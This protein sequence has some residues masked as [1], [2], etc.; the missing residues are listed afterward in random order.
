M[1]KI[2]DKVIMEFKEYL[3]WGEKSENTIEKYIRDITFFAR[4]LCGKEVTKILVLEYKKELCKKYAS[5]SVNG[6]ISSLNSFFGF[7]EWHDARIKS[8]KIQRQIFSNEKRELTKAEY[9]RLLR[10]AKNKNDKRLYFLMQTVC[11][12]GIRISDDI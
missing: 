6:A 12:T 7:M 2:T 1:R 3:I 9:E 10:A 4:W 8:L 11:S 5:A